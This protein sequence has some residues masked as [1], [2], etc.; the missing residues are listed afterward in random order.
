MKQ[1]LLTL[2]AILGRE[3]LPTENTKQEHIVHINGVFMHGDFD[4]N[5]VDMAAPAIKAFLDL[6][7]DELRTE[8]GLSL[9]KMQNLKIGVE[10][11]KG[12]PDVDALIVLGLA[13]NLLEFTTPRT[14]WDISGT[15]Q[16]LPF[17]RMVKPPGAGER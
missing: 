12:P 16:V 2:L 7:P 13:A 3:V 17:V 10:W 6:L 8:K 5:S 4:Q 11:A 15:P 14:K 9:D 1:L